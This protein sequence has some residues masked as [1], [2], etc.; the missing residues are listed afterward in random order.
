MK[1]PFYL[2][3]RARK[4]GKPIWYVR[5]PR[6]DGSISVA[7]SSGQT[8]R[9]A[10]AEWARKELAKAQAP[11]SSTV[12]EWAERFFRPKCPH[13]DRMRLEGKLYGDRTEKNY[14][15]QLDAI[16]SDP[17]FDLNLQTLRRGDLLAFR[18][19]MAARYGARRIAQL[20]YSILR[21]IIR[22][23]VYHEMIDHDPTAGIGQIKV[24]GK[25]RKA[26]SADDIRKLLDPAQYPNRL[27]YEATFTA[28]L[29]GLRAGEVRALQWDDLDE[30]KGVI[31]VTRN[32][33]ANDTEAKLP[34]WGKVRITAYPKALQKV[35]EPRRG[36]GWVFMGP[37]GV[38]GYARWAMAFRRAAKAAQIEG[39]TLHGLRHSLLTMLRDQGIPDEKLRAAFGWT[40]SVI[41]TYTHR[42]LYDY[43]PQAKAIDSLLGGKN[44]KARG[45]RRDKP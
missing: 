39:A 38:M 32:L 15:R 33:P 45:H 7:R 43:A 29:T 1:L 10:A 6:P 8:N 34:K 36:V 16:I 13:G 12:R 26:F 40:G 28:A 27:H 42:D 20:S 3:A 24:E 25:R 2:S 19:R 17:V 14:K 23:A 30:Q 18:S 44:G 11:T 31:R 21:L 37:D 22:E 4:G 35:L 5:F 9:E 41:E